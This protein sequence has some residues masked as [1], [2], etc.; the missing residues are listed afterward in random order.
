M[1]RNTSRLYWLWLTF[2]RLAYSKSSNSSFSA[3]AVAAI[4]RRL[5]FSFI[6]SR[7]IIRLAA[8]GT[9]KGGSVWSFAGFGGSKI[10]S[11]LPQMEFVRSKARVP[12][13]H[14]K[15]APARSRADRGDPCFGRLLHRT[16]R[17]M[18][19]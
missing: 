3:S 14:P 10:L 2:V 6:Q 12:T 5:A 16:N 4:S 7:L 19:S 18:N 9:G 15:F 8:D 17:R 13:C 1:E 11:E